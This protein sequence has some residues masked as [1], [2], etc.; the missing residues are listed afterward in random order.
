M[1][2]ASDPLAVRFVRDGRY[3]FIESAGVSSRKH[4]ALRANPVAPY[5]RVRRRP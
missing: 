1:V 4:Y 5:E 2:E 3:D